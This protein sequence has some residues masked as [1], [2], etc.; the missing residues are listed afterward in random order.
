MRSWRIRNGR[1]WSSLSRSEGELRKGGGG[2]A[3]LHAGSVPPAV[4]T[5]PAVRP[6]VGCRHDPASGQHQRLRVRA[7][8][9]RGPG[10]HRDRGGSRGKT[11]SDRRFTGRTVRGS[12]RTDLLADLVSRLGR[13]A[14]A[15][16]SEAPA[17]RPPGRPVD[18]L[19]RPA[20][21]WRTALAHGVGPDGGP[22]CPDRADTVRLP[23]RGAV[24][25]RPGHPARSA[26]PAHGGGAPGGAAGGSVRHLLRLEVGAGG[27][28]GAGRGGRDVSLGGGIAGRHTHRAGLFGGESGAES[29][30]GS[31]C[32]P[33]RC[34]APQRPPLRRVQ[35]PDGVPRL[36]RVR[37]G[38][39]LRREPDARGIALTGK[40]DLVS[41]LHVL[42]RDVGGPV[43]GSLCRLQ[44]IAWIERPSV[45]VARR[46]VRDHRSAEA[47]EAW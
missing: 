30:R 32:R 7:H 4:R 33:A 34:A 13:G 15:A 39:W 46:A 3:V 43:G 29:V 45:R 20:A 40:A 19:L 27:A 23:G 12:W 11:G 6:A 41:S 14:P 8:A 5:G 37:P 25:R 31:A 10:G 42:D 18:R 24:C 38:A 17:L 28:G 1:S 44:A 26:H 36:H 47:G 9:G 16:G 35:R 22:E 2:R 21:G